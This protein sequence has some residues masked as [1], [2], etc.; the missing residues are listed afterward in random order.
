MRAFHR[1][2]PLTLMVSMHYPCPRGPMSQ[3]SHWSRLRRRQDDHVDAHVLAVAA[4]T[5]LDELGVLGQH[6][7]V[8]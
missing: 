2:P 8:P 7:G 3:A 6:H 1:C 5:I 4:P